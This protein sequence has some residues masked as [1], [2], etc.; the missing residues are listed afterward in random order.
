MIGDKPTL[1]QAFWRGFRR[2]WLRV[3][4]WLLPAWLW[5]LYACYFYD[6]KLCSEDRAHPG[7]GVTVKL[8]ELDVDGGE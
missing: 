7:G 8:D 5:I 4:L 6:P 3:Q 2:G 1:R